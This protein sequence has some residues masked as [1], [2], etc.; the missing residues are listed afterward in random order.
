MVPRRKDHAVSAVLEAHPGPH[1]RPV[2]KDQTRCFTGTG[3]AK[4]CPV[5]LRRIEGWNPEKQE[6][7]VFLTHHFKRGATTI[8]TIYQDRWQIE[9]CFKALKQ[10]RKIKT[11][12]GPSATAVKSQVGTA[13]I[14][15]L[16]VRS[17]HLK[18]RVAWSRSKLVALLR[19][20]LFT[21]RDLGGG[22]IRRSHHR[23][24]SCRCR[25]RQRGPGN[26]DSTPEGLT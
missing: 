5:R 12:G 14:A 16:L 22:S 24:S 3:T 1:P 13:L 10:T 26:A 2:R 23:P 25:S 20:N 11:G 7:L 6:G 9:R 8:A 18:A 17:L 19:M 21:H 4:T 15:R